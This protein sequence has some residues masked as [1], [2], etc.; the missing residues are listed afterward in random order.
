VNDHIEMLLLLS[1]LCFFINFGSQSRQTR[2]AGVHTKRFGAGGVPVDSEEGGSPASARSGP[3]V[4][5]PA[6]A[7]ESPARASQ[8]VQAQPTQSQPVQ[9]QVIQSGASSSAAG[10][11]SQP[12]PAAC[13]SEATQDKQITAW[14]ALLT[15]C[16]DNKHLSKCGPPTNAEFVISA[17]E[18]N[19]ETELTFVVNSFQDGKGYRC[20]L[21]WDESIIPCGK[22]VSTTNGAPTDRRVLPIGPLGF[23]S[24]LLWA[25]TGITI[26]IY[27]GQKPHWE[28]T[29]NQPNN[30]V[31][32]S[33]LKS[34]LAQGLSEHERFLNGKSVYL[35]M[36]DNSPLREIY[37]LMKGNG[38]TYLQGTWSME[39]E[40]MLNRLNPSQRQAFYTV[41]R[42]VLTTPAKQLLTNRAY[43]PI[44]NALSWDNPIRHFG[45]NFKTEMDDFYPEGRDFGEMTAHEVI[46]EFIEHWKSKKKEDNMT[47]IYSAAEQ[48]HLGQDTFVYFFRYHSN[49]EL[50]ARQVLSG[51]DDACIFMAGKPR[52]TNPI[53][54][55]YEY[56]PRAQNPPPPQPAQGP[57]THVQDV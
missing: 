3:N 46:K 25:V 43:D 29:Q 44:K 32:D 31:T 50:L 24:G 2:N 41:S 11:S 49:F 21:E 54:F 37:W 1:L 22:I 28:L 12:V 35:R 53:S 15:A 38:F 9:A 55:A 5:S 33:F 36:S 47:P 40:C 39:Y 57:R 26:D 30:L 7:P 19:R 23:S 20:K 10:S 8:P 42:T 17:T 6:S 34:F 27:G 56:R 51:Y 18:N 13:T 14:S 16:F 45:D 48:I 4:G 52:D